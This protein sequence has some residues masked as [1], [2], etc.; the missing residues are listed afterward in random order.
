MSGSAS[1]DAGELP[2]L[3]PHVSTRKSHR[4][5]S[6]F[7]PSATISNERPCE[8]PAQ[9]QVAEVGGEGGESQSHSARDVSDQA[10]SKVR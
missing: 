7:W 1:M 5:A 6:T 3:L 2:I 4:T 8:L 10:G 9:G